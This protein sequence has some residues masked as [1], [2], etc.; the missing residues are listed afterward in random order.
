[1][2]VTSCAGAEVVVLVVGAL[3]LDYFDV[4]KKWEG[5]EEWKTKGRK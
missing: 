4:Q 1:M 5:V 3:L 2:S